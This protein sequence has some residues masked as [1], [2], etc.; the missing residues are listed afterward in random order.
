MLESEIEPR[1]SRMN[2]LLSLSNGLAAAV[3]HVASAVVTVNARPRL[4][5]TGVHWR[6]GVVVTADHTVRAAEDITITRSDGRTAPAPPGGRDPGPNL[7]G[8]ALSG[9]DVPAG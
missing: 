9:G 8:C 3:E 2:T 4:A 1:R 7:P 6:S 5:S